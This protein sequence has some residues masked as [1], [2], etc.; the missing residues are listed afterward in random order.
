MGLLLVEGGD[1]ERIL[2]DDAAAAVV[3]LA[4]INV[5]DDDIN[6]NVFGGRGSGTFGGG[7]GGG[8]VRT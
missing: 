1:N 8:G 3:L 6:E 7:R 5:G 2:V 4:F